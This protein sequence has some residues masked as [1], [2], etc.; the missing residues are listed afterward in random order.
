MRQVIAATRPAK[1]AL[2]VK[3][4]ALFTAVALAAGLTTLPAIA[5]DDAA[6]PRATSLGGYT[7][8]PKTY[9]KEVGKEFQGAVKPKTNSLGDAAIPGAYT[10]IVGPYQFNIAGNTVTT[11]KYEPLLGAEGAR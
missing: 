8:V 9:L 6:A 5:D 1:R 11:G 3:V 4:L 10:S 7:A 2:F